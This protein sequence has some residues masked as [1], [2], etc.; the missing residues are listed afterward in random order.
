MPNIDELF[1][2]RHCDLEIIILCVVWV[3]IAIGRG[4]WTFARADAGGQ[5]AAVIPT[6]PI[7]T[8]ELN[9]A[10]SPAWL[11]HV[12]A[13]PRDRSAKRRDEWPPWNWTPRQQALTE[14]A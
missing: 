2:L 8:G 14:A 4:N 6:P 13:K 10:D 3:G 7:E 11:A 1:K 9:D 12:L 5:G